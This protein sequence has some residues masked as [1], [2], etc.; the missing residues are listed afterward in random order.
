[1]G[2]VRFTSCVRASCSREIW[3]SSG[4]G[5]TTRKS[6]PSPSSST[7]ALP[8]KVSLSNFPSLATDCCSSYVARIGWLAVSFP[9]AARTSPRGSAAS[10]SEARARTSANRRKFMSIRY[11]EAADGSFRAVTLTRMSTVRTDYPIRRII[12][13]SGLGTMIEWYDFYIFG[14]LAVIMS[15]AH[16]PEGRSDR[17]LSSRPGHCSPPASRAAVRRDRL[18]PHRRSG[19]TQVRVPGHAADHGRLST[20][21]IGLLPTYATDRHARAARSCSCCGSCRDWPSAASTAAR[22]STSPSTCPTIERGFYTS[23]IQTT[24]TLG[25]FVSL[26]V[27]L[28]V[29]R[30]DV[31]RGLSRPGAGACRSCCRSCWWACRSTSAC[32]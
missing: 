18:R 14:S 19:R 2:V 8:L 16:L 28:G 1:M 11:D 7:A 32:A 12:F 22:R 20:F 9:N 21:V 26:G 10:G 6:P 5:K 23:F 25:L 29:T 15:E 30:D 24:A 4:R 31:R 17:G 3:S 13:A 27:I